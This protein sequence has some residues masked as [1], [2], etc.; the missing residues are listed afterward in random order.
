MPQH[1]ICPHCQKAIPETVF[2]DQIKHQL[3]HEFDK[4]QHN[5]LLELTKKAKELEAQANT[6]KQQ[7]AAV[8]EEKKKLQETVKEQLEAEKKKI[9][10]VAQQK[11]KE[12]ADEENSVKFKEL[13]EENKKKTEE[14][15]KAEQQELELRKKTRE[16]E[17]RS[18]KLELEVQRKI[19]EERKKIAEDA[20]KQADDDSRSKIMEMQKQLQDAAKAND[21]LKR[22]LEQGSM[23]I[24]GEVQEDDLKQLLQIAFP[25]DQISDVEKGVKGADLIQVVMNNL[26]QQCGV[27]LWESKNTQSWK[28]E[29]VKKL[30]EDQNIVKADV[31]VIVSKVLP[32]G[33][34]SHT[35]I[36]NV[37]AVN[38]QSVLLLTQA[39][40]I[41][42]QQIC[43]V[44]SSLV[45]REEKMEVLYTYLSGSQFKNRVENIVSAFISM[46]EQ[47]V[48][49]RRAMNAIW[50]RREKEIER[51]I[52]NTTGMYGDLQGIIGG[53]LPAIQQLELEAGEDSEELSL[54]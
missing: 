41:Q 16:I 5:K 52:N 27:I 11:A 9:W 23:Q 35:V 2:S 46:Q 33:V 6:M 20:K 25:L 39:L 13:E 18:A 4:E 10:V 14:L 3:Q 50:N 51:V 8:E 48:K 7:Q 34:D 42:L 36:Q 26:G 12:K 1:F 53:S 54:F 15:R 31:C 49:E 29:W 45:G 40:R 44:R 19:D 17:E 47:L 38:Y 32:K 43:Q 24:Q 30:K 28:D 22:K 37:W 21:D